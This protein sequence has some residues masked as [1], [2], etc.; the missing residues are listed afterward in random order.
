MKQVTKLTFIGSPD[1]K[2]PIGPN[3]LKNKKE[4]NK[5][6]ITFKTITEFIDKPINIFCMGSSGNIIACMLANKLKK[7][8]IVPIRKA[9]EYSHSGNF[10]LH[11]HRIP[12]AINIIVDDFI[13][14]GE[15]MEAIFF[16]M[17]LQLGK[18]IK[19]DCIAILGYDKYELLSFQSKYFISRETWNH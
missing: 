7:A 3:F 9:K 16:E 8:I 12:N 1:W 18:K 11:K 10:D 6:I 17:Q 15:T 5:L 2:Y 4:I 14:S 19:I 13:D